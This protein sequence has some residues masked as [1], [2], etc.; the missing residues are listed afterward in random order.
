M[1][2]AEET[3][4]NYCISLN[5]EILKQLGVASDD[6]LGAIM[7]DPDKAPIEEREKAMLKAV[8]TACSNPEALN[9]AEVQGLR[10]Q[11]WNDGDILDAITHGL[12]MVQGGMLEKAVGLPEGAAC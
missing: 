11:G 6:E 10:E 4:Y 2:V 3:Q 5:R 7:A 9:E 8:L 12:M 1:L